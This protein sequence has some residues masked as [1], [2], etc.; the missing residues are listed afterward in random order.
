MSDRGLRIHQVLCV[1][2][3]VL[4][5]VFGICDG[6]QK[7]ESRAPTGSSSKTELFTSQYNSSSW[8]FFLI[9]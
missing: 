3:V 5:G 8:R 9:N 6:E 2:L 1:L 4:L 7:V